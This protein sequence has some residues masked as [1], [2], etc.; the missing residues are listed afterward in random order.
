MQTAREKALMNF[1]R[2][3]LL[4]PLLAVLSAGLTPG[5]R[6]QNSGGTLSREELAGKKLFYQR[7][8]ICHLQ[9][10]R[11][12]VRTTIPYAPRL[13]GFVHDEATAAQAKTQ[14]RNGSPGLMPGFQYGLAPEEIDRIVAYLKTFK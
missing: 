9:P 7:C 14:I 5:L 13:N 6:A 2:A 12:R 10:L 4:T 11:D 1:K 8:S 3:V